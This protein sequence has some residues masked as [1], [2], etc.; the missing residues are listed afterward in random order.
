LI[1]RGF[2]R[3]KAQA[4]AAEA[5]PRHDLELRLAVPQSEFVK[6][7]LADDPELADPIA[8]ECR[9]V[10]VADEHQVGREVLDARGEIV[11]AVLDAKP[12]SRSSPRL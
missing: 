5:Q 8:Y 12:G 1:G 4:A 9:D 2:R 6:H 11:L 3:G 10:V 7:I